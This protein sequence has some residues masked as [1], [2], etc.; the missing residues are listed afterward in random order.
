MK[1]A[2]PAEQFRKRLEELKKG[3]LFRRL[4]P[5]DPKQPKYAE[6]SFL[7]G[8]NFLLLAG[9]REWV[10]AELPVIRQMGFLFERPRAHLQLNLRVV[11]LTGTANSD[12]IQ[13][14][15]TVRS[16]VANQR[17]EV[18]RAFSDLQSYLLE[19]LRRRNRED[20]RVY[21]EVHRLLPSLGS[22]ERPQTVPEILL[23][24]M[25]DRT[26][27]ESQGEMSPT[28]V[29]ERTENALTTLPHRLEAELSDPQRTDP[30]V[31]SEIQSDLQE[32]KATVAV[33]RDWCNDYARALG[34]KDGG[35]AGTL[36]SALEQP[37]CPL[38]SWIALRLRRSISLTDRLYPALVQKHS[39]HALQE[40][41]RRFQRALER[42]EAVE[43]D[44]AQSDI[45]APARGSELDGEM[46]R[47]EE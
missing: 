41:E 16:L 7:T 45:D 33:A 30:A 37:D 29:G 18:L 46:R 11:Q 34:R 35:A 39:V 13:M 2:Q 1:D 14:T 40:L 5:G 10:D 24:L 21:Q 20:L 36:Q 43:Q 28:G 44:L 8:G 12:V 22:D 32:W 6:I 15:E 26:L 3:G 42:A 31:I 27:P 25:L 9:E 17:A 19:R 38:P 47:K 23:L 4:L